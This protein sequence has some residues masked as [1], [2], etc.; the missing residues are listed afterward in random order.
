MK[1]KAKG[2]LLFIIIAVIAGCAAN[3]NLGLNSDDVT[4]LLSDN[5]SHQSAEED[6]LIDIDELIEAFKT[7]LHNDL[8]YHGNNSSYKGYQNKNTNIEVYVNPLHPQILTIIPDIKLKG[9]D[10]SL[11]VSFVSTFTIE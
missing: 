10:V 7:A 8:W 11:K 3:D 6:N 2:V 9:E 5:S 4:D 1:N